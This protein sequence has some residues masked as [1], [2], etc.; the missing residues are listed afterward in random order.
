[1]V[2]LRC[3]AIGGVEENEVY[4]YFSRGLVRTGFCVDCGGQGFL[5]RAW[6]FPTGSGV[7]KLRPLSQRAKHPSKTSYTMGW[8]S[9]AAKVGESP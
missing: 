8:L 1:M 2:F 6:T 5:C 7:L 4:L 9:I 3:G